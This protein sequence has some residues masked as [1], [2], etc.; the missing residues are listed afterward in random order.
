MTWL[1][2]SLPTLNRR[3]CSIDPEHPQRGDPHPGCKHLAIRAV[4]LADV[5][6]PAPAIAGIPIA[7]R[8]EH[9][10]P[11]PPAPASRGKE[12]PRALPPSEPQGRGRQV[13]G[14]PRHAPPQ[15]STDA[16]L[17]PRAPSHA[18]LARA[19]TVARPP[20]GGGG[21]GRPRGVGEH[22]EE[23]HGHVPRRGL[24]LPLVVAV[25]GARV[26]GGRPPGQHPDVVILHRRERREGRGCEPRRRPVGHS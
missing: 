12:L 5:E 17:L 24:H 15:P 6:P 20:T 21:V 14:R 25:G 19:A 23:E 8:E 3:A 9:L 18:H 2:I 10:R 11:R 1:S 16:S 7:L 22:V 4:G 26:E 13:S